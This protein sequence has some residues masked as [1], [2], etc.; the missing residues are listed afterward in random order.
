MAQDVPIRASSGLLG[1]CPGEG[2]AR[3]S[4]EPLSCDPG[5]I[6]HTRRW[7]PGWPS[8]SRAVAAWR[9]GVTK[10]AWHRRLPHVLSCS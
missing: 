10:L 4:R 3:E 8:R 2:F 5:G 9:A 1:L 7:V 6:P